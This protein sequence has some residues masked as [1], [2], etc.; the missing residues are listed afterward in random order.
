ARIGYGFRMIRWPRRPVL[1]RLIAAS[2]TPL[3]LGGSAIGTGLAATSAESAITCTN[4]ASGTTWQIKVDYVHSTVD[5]NA[6][7]ISDSKISWHDAKDGGN[8]TL[9]RKSGSLTFVAPSSTGGYFIFDRCSLDN[10]G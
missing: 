6:A 3:A 9:D 8:Y 5:A 10:P 2:V 7:S 4:P 1:I